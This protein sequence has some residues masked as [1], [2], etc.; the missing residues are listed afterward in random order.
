MKSI[1]Q[2][3]QA[4]GQRQVYPIIPV[5][6]NANRD[7]CK[8][9]QAKNQSRHSKD[10]HFSVPAANFLPVTARNTSSIFPLVIS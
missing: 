5:R 8:R 4:K 7:G 6:E 3:A 9:G 10:F 2:G 1:S